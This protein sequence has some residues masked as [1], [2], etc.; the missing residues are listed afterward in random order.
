MLRKSNVMSKQLGFLV[1]NA[2]GT[3]KNGALSVLVIHYRKFDV[4]ELRGVGDVI[5]IE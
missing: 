4:F 1:L 3:H 5:Q 2:S